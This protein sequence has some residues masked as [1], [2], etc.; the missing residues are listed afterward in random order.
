MIE[1]SRPFLL[2][3]V[4]IIPI[5]FY[6]FNRYDRYR[7]AL[8][9]R[10]FDRSAWR[11]LTENSGPRQRRRLLLWE[12][13]ALLLLILAA[14]GPRVGTRLE[15]LKREG[16][17]IM[18]AIDLSRSMKTEDISPDRLT[19]S[20]LEVQ[21]FIGELKGDRVG[22]IAFAGIAHLQC[23][24]TLDH[25][26]AVMLL[27]VMDETLLPVQGTALAEAVDI[28]VKSF[29]ENGGKR[30]RALI[31]ISDG[32]DHE[33]NVESA[34]RKAAEAGI[35]VYSLGVGTLKGGPIPVYDRNDQLLDYKRNSSGQIVTS[36]LQEQNLSLLSDITGGIYYR[37]YETRD[38]L[39][40]IYSDMTNLERKEFR[41]HDFSKYLELYQF[42]LFPAF[43][44]LFAAYLDRGF[45][46]RSSLFPLKNTA[47]RGRED[48][49]GAEQ[50]T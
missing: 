35:T 10:G 30:D 1:F 33:Q 24:L 39:Q 19:R 20:K 26:A 46:S 22:L 44:I 16:L 32:E 11:R 7:R 28:A 9:D 6:I 43:L 47:R 2:F 3:A 21:K 37:L 34:A 41:T 23:P 40:K 4:L 49:L 50:G 25:S 13:T 14:A 17:D 36:Q 45:W 31:I 38:P 5:L 18:V 8:L 12:M 15:E 27:N 48:S 42:L 29:P